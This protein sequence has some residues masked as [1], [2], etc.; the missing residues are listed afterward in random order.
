MTSHVVS[1]TKEV[2]PRLAEHPLKTKGR[3]AN[4]RLTSFVKD[5]NGPQRVTQTIDSQRNFEE[6]LS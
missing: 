2:N 3:L 6:N 5:A 4:R 1:F